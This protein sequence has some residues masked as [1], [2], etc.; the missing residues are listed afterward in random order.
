MS[1]SAQ[2]AALGGIAIVLVLA[3]VWILF[4]A[5]RDP[6]ARERKRRLEVHQRGRLGD[7]LISGTDDNNIYYSYSI[8]GVDYST[9]QNVMSLRDFVP[10][11]SG[12]I[13][14]Q[15]AHIKYMV[16]NPGNSILLCEQWSGLRPKASPAS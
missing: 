10:S 4:S 11:D 3:G 6:E 1:P 8:S 13:I 7:A 16:N 2:I 5:R 12:S 15:R 14:G 9:A